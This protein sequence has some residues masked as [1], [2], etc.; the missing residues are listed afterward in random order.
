[1]EQS[2]D[3]R[4]ALLRF[5]E[6]FSSGEAGTFAEVIATGVGVSVI[7]TEPGQGAGDRETWLDTYTTQIAPLGVEIRA[8]DPIGFA[9]GDVGFAT[10]TPTAFLPD[11]SYVPLRATAVFHLEGGAWK[12]IHLHFSVGVPDEDVI[13]PPD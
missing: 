11:R 3:V 4:D 7:G 10:D 6:A 5:Y 1:V 13:Q 2:S 12:L 9:E 8:G